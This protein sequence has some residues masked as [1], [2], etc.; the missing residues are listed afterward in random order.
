VPVAQG[1]VKLFRTVLSAGSSHGVSHL[2]QGWPTR[3]VLFIPAGWRGDCAVWWLPHTPGT[4]AVD[5]WR[6][7]RGSEL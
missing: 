7:G 5:L 4:V 6:W 3:L 2:L 1:L